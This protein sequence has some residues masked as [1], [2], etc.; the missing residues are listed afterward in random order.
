VLAYFIVDNEVTDLPGFEEHRKQVPGTVALHA[1]D[2]DH[3][4]PRRAQPDRPSGEGRTEV[5]GLPGFL[6]RPVIVLAGLITHRSSAQIR[7]PQPPNT[8]EMIQVSAV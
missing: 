2:Q 6:Q 4:T 5:S 8:P 1:F 3:A 7:P